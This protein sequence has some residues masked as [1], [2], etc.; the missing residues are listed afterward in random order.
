MTEIRDKIL[1]IFNGDK[2]GEHDKLS[3]TAVKGQVNSMHAPDVAELIHDLESKHQAILFRLLEKELAIEVFEELESFVQQSLLEGMSVSQVKELLHEMSSDDRANL[4]DE[5]PAKVVQKFLGQISIK[6]RQE[7]LSILGYNPDSAGRLMTLEYVILKE[8][9]T[10]A[11]AIEKIKRQDF[12]KETVY[13]AYVT[14][15]DRKIL[16]VVSL[17]QLLF[18]ESDDK[19]IDIART[20]VIKVT[21]NTEREEVANIMMRYDLL[22]IPVVDKEERLVGII[23][24]D[25]VIDIVEEEATEDFKKIIG[26]SAEEELTGDALHTISKRLPWLLLNIALYV[27][28]SS[29]VSPFQDLIS[30]IPVIAVIL[31]MMSNS[32]G[33]VAIQVLTIT[34]R[35]LATDSIKVSDA[36]RV[37]RK[38]LLASVGIAVGLG[39]FVGLISMLWIDNEKNYIIAP[40]AAFIMGANALMA[41]VLGVTVPVVLKKFRL[42]P[43]LVSGPVLT[44]VLDALGFLTFLSTIEW[45]H[46]N[47]L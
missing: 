13:Y 28:A 32:S 5:M 23:T 4:F 42:D 35:G 17:K 18:G 21:T 46:G 3:L 40:L 20:N 29:V 10:V 33:N 41:S 25:D 39:V 2:Q 11:S 24:I 26:G 43:A 38:E 14:T 44:T 45:W 36:F 27:L 6:D 1:T 37:I 30:L 15:G 12:D 22:A 8:Q 47:S 19:I 31:P 16:G 7:T 34:V 9:H